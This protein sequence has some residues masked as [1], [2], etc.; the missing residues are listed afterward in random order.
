MQTKHE[1]LD[2]GGGVGISIVTDPKFKTNLINVRFL[3]EYDRDTAAAMALIPQILTSMNREYPDSALFNRKLNALY[4]T[5]I[6]GS[7]RQRGKIYETSLTVTYLRDRF[8]LDGD[9]VSEKVIKLFLGCIFDPALEDGAFAKTEFNT[10]K[11]NLL[12]AIDSE[13]NDK[14][15]YAMNKAFEIAYRGESSAE[16]H[17]GS[18]EEVEALTPERAYEVYKNLLK[19]ARIEISF[20]GGGEF[21]ETVRIFTEAFKTDRTKWADPEYY[22]P[23]PCK[24]EPEYGELQLDVQQAILVLIFKANGADSCAMTLLSWLY[25]ETPF[26]KLFLNVRERMS[27]CYFCSSS[28]GDTK[29]TL[30]VGGGVAPENIE[31]AK[32]EMLRQLQLIAD[33]DFTDED[34]ANTKSALANAYRSIYDKSGRLEDWY[35]VQMLKGSNDSP[36]E[37]MANIQKVTREEI[38]AAAKSVRLDTVFVLKNMD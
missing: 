18:R 31:V 11:I 27:L 32:N 8:A 29:D 10:R 4:G 13:I 5:W 3:T 21:E 38:I 19:T 25:G 33:G 23:S 20:S 37:K 15:S 1:R 28:Y 34:V 24:P 16:R 2:L 26:S 36:E 17:F 9:K 35:F 22:Y 6:W 12:S 7:S 30:Y 14:V